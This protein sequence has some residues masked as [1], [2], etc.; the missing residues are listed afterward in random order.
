ML[1]EIF[2]Y[3]IFLLRI[4]SG[5]EQMFCIVIDIFINLSLTNIVQILDTCN[6]LN[7]GFIVS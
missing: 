6:R 4:L 3:F 5:F 7:I 1:S 2:H